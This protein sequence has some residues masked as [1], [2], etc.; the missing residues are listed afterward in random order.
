MDVKS[1]N[2]QISITVPAQYQ[3][4]VTLLQQVSHPSAPVSPDDIVDCIELQSGKT[5]PAKRQII[6]YRPSDSPLIKDR[7]KFID[8]WV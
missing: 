8:I 7:G 5:S 6:T 3:R 1:P 4:A 2:T